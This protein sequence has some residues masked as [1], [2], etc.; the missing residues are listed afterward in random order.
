MFSVRTPCRVGEVRVLGRCSTGT[1]ENRVPGSQYSVQFSSFEDLD[2][3][4]T[5]LV[6]SQQ[7]DISLED[8]QAS[9]RTKLRKTVRLLWSSRAAKFQRGPGR[10]PRQADD[11][12]LPPHRG[13]T[14]RGRAFPGSV[15]PTSHTL[16]LSHS[17]SCKGSEAVVPCA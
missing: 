2:F 17:T 3:D 1:S 8:F 15:E 7:F 6:N 5:C 9:D 4:S 10:R 14:P 11:F 16:R 12:R 13:G